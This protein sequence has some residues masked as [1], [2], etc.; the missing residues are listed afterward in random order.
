MFSSP[1][2]PTNQSLTMSTI[3]KT[4]SQTCTG[5][6]FLVDQFSLYKKSKGKE[7]IDPSL[8]NM[9]DILEVF[10]KHPEVSGYKEGWFPINSR[11]TAVAFKINKTK[12][13]AQK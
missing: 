6:N 12:D 13:R 4:W 5:R 11:D 10:A 9:Q 8:R 3:S 7:G 2:L 1:P